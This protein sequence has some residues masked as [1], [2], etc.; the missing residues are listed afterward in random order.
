M[1]GRLSTLRRYPVKSMHGEEIESS[2]ATERGLTGD[3]AYALIDAVDGKLGSSLG[4][5]AWR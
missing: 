3:R 4:H 1:K 5:G 2:P